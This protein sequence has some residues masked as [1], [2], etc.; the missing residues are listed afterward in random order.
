M[1]HDDVAAT[2]GL[3]KTQNVGK[4]QQQFRKFKNQHIYYK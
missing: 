2:N 3:A 4:V 1:P